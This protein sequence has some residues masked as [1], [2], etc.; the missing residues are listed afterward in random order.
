MWPFSRSPTVRRNIERQRAA[1]RRGK[2][3]LLDS[4]ALVSM[5]TVTWFEP[6]DILMGRTDYL[7]K[8]GSDRCLFEVACFAHARA[9]FLL[10]TESE[11]LQKA[12]SDPLFNCLTT[13]FTGICGL[14][15]DEIA[16]RLNNRL[17]VYGPLF[18]AGPDAQ[19]LHDRLAVA[20]HGTAAMER[21]P[22][23]MTLEMPSQEALFA[24]MSLLM[25]LPTWDVHGLKLL[26]S[27]IEEG[28]IT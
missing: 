17:A 3:T 24:H 9:D 20:I 23:Q 2:L 26:K 14:T 1:M 19:K 10:F 8:C 16:Q 27:F 15:N 22:L 21:P 5:G 12:G 7:D 25:T 4:F 11:D 13:T 28:L 18:A 6:E